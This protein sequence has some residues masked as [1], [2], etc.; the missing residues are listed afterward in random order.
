MKKNKE[1]NMEIKTK[2]EYTADRLLRF[3]TVHVLRNKLRWFL[4]SGVTIVFFVMSMLA[5]IKG[6]KEND[7][8]GLIFYSA[9]FAIILLLDAYML[10]VSF[11]IPRFKIKKAPVVGAILMVIFNDEG[12][13]VN[14]HTD[15]TD[16]N[17]KQGYG[18]IE[19]VIKKGT[20]LYLYINKSNAYIVDLS[21]ASLEEVA[22]L[23]EKFTANVK[24]I[25]WK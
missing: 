1:I 19:T 4:Y 8:K 16:S 24:N 10:F 2:T 18:S 20:E 17:T 21:N 15:N 3:N 7:Y 12:I 13:I 22:F 5:L 6:I 11:V 14:G 9:I 25:I 23:K